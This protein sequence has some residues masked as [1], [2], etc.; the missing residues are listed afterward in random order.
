MNKYLDL[1]RDLKNME[2]EGHG[3]T[4]SDFGIWIGL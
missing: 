2:Y 3:S 1:A 4:D